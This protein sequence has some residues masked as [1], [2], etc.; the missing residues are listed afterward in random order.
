MEP[1]QDTSRPEG[2]VEKKYR[3]LSKCIIS[4]AKDGRLHVLKVTHRTMSDLSYLLTGSHHEL[5]N[6]R[7]RSILPRAEYY[8]VQVRKMA[9]EGDND[10]ELNYEFFI[11]PQHIVFYSTIPKNFEVAHIPKEESA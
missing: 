7:A 11:L 8:M 9:H 5:Q 3:G 10:H 2:N 6:I 4:E 1:T